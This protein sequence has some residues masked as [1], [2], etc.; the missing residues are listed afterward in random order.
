MF[1]WTSSANRVEAGA[2]SC[3]RPRPRLRGAGRT[4]KRAA[5]SRPPGVQRRG[6]AG[7]GGALGCTSA[8]YGFV[9]LCVFFFLRP[10]SSSAAGVGK[11]GPWW[12]RGW[13]DGVARLGTQRMGLWPGVGSAGGRPQLRGAH[14]GPG[15][16]ATART[17]VMTPAP[18]CFSFGPSAPAEHPRGRRPCGPVGLPSLTPVLTRL[19]L[20]PSRFPLSPC[21]SS[22]LAVPPCP[23][24]GAQ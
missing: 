11:V 4:A 7:R 9:F 1:L 21:Q 18:G 2:L 5:P 12:G 20:S 8:L 22:L 19:F 16:A 6:S 14:C 3:A 15:P 17:Q 24:P 13:E 23:E 10:G